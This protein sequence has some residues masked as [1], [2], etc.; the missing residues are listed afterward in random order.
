MR[1][2]PAPPGPT[3]SIV[4]PMVSVATPRLR[5]SVMMPPP[6]GG[7]V[8]AKSAVTDSQ[9]RVAAIAVAVDAAGVGVGGVTA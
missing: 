8:V 5:P 2:A 7:L 3:F 9:P 6:L 1:F 4:F